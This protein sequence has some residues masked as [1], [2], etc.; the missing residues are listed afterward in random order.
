MEKHITEDK[1]QQLTELDDLLPHSPNNIAMIEINKT[2]KSILKILE[3]ER[4]PYHLNLV[5]KQFPHVRPNLDDDITV[6]D[7]GNFIRG[8][9]QENIK[10]NTSFI[11]R[12]ENGYMKYLPD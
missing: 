11:C 9:Y 12:K 1:V 3:T 8:I 4:S 2:L 5:F 6:I 7:S 10:N